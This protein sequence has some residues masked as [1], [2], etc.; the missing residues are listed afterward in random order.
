MPSLSS[1]LHCLSPAQCFRPCLPPPPTAVEDRVVFDPLHL[2]GPPTLFEL[3]DEDML[4]QENLDLSLVSDSMAASRLPPPGTL[5]APPTS[6]SMPSLADKFCSFSTSYSLPQPPLPL[7]SSS[8]DMRGTRQEEGQSGP[9]IPPPAAAEA[10][11]QQPPTHIST[12]PVVEAL[13]VL[14]PP[15]FAPQMAVSPIAPAYNMTSSFTATS[16]ASAR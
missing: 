5:E 9:Q 3:D 4:S 8:N 6:S 7:D 11:L 14:S 2:P 15:E 12:Q 1:A 10:L 13:P 16:L